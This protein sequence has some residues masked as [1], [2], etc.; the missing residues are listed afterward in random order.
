[1]FGI[2]NEQ[3]YDFANMANLSV[4]LLMSIALTVAISYVVG[5]PR[6]EKVFLRR[7]RRFFRQA[8]FLMSH[9][10]LDRD[11]RKGLTTRFRMALCR[12]SLLELPVKL[13]AL[14]PNIDYRLLPGQTPEQVQDLANSLQAVAYRLN[15]LVEARKA[16]QADLLVAEL[17]D[18]M[19]AWRTL[20]QEQFRLW[21]D[22][23]AL[24]VA[25]GAEMQDR[26]L[27]QISKLEAR[28][29][30]TFRGIEDGQLSGE[31]Y[32]NFYR[33]LGACRGLSES[34]IAYALIAQGIDWGLWQEARF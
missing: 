32:E 6:P 26:L 16:P 8:E 15:E 2:Q 21:A 3:T 19:R 27:A 25:P 4:I 17:I 23:P 34:G 20:A 22:N 11:E 1:L 5:S 10:A 24:A 30:E 33:Y 13:A 29:D 28:I 31:D 12:N 9:L 14:G 18:D 7:L